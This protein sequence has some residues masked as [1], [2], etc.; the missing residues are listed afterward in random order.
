MTIGDLGHWFLRLHDD[1]HRSR[2]HVPDG[3]ARPIL[4]LLGYAPMSPLWWRSEA[5]RDHHISW[6][7]Y[8]GKRTTARHP[9]GRMYA[10]KGVLPDVCSAY[11]T[12]AQL[13]CL[14]VQAAV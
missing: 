1:E 6:L 10:R 5:S 8:G 11:T 2:A 3:I 13:N 7:Y 9:A 14:V 4:E 12:R